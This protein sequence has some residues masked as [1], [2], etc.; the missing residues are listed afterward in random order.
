MVHSN[1]K[2]LFRIIPLLTAAAALLCA[3][4]D[5][6]P[7]NNDDGIDGE[8]ISGYK[9]KSDEPSVYYY[10]FFNLDAVTEPLEE[11]TSGVLDSDG[12][13]IRLTGGRDIHTNSGITRT[14]G[15]GGVAFSGSTDFDAD[16][17][18]PASLDFETDFEYWEYYEMSAGGYAEPQ[19]YQANV[20]SFPGYTS[21][22]GYNGGSA[23]GTADGLTEDTA[24]LRGNIDWSGDAYAQWIGMPPSFVNFSKNVYVIRSG[25]GNRYYKFQILDM[26]YTTES[27][28][29]GTKKVTYAYE[30]RSEKIGQ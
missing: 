17:S 26:E 7:L 23:D 8:V 12:W 1:K 21:A 4:C 18:D 14:G 22:N 10:S 3:S 2:T 5:T 16:I 15:S 29:D 20:M 27:R 30:V 24:Y 6:D 25:D 28:D 19:T 11:N 13:D 9:I